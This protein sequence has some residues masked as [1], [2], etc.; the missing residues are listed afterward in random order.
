MLSTLRIGYGDSTQCQASDLALPDR[1]RFLPLKG[2]LGVN[3]RSEDS[4]STGPS[5]REQLPPLLEEID[6]H[7]L[8][9]VV[10][11]GEEGATS[12]EPRQFLNEVA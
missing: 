5:T 10:G 1:H 7:V 11:T 9:E 4:E 2:G 3:L 6:Q 8:P 12:V